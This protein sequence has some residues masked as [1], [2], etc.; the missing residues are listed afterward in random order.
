M[1][2]KLHAHQ[3]KALEEMKNG[4]ILYGGVGVGKTITSLAYYYTKVCGGEL[5]K[6]ASMS[7]P[8]DVYVITTA[9]VRDSQAF[10]L[11]AGK[12]GVHQ[13]PAVSTNGVKITVDSWNNLHKYTEVKDAFFI[14]DEQRVVGYGSWARA[15]I[16]VAKSNEWILLSATPG[17]TWLDYIP[18]FIANGWYKHKT[19]F[20]DQHVIWTPRV[21]YPKVLRYQNVGVLVKRRNEVLVHMPLERHTKR[22]PIDVVCDYDHDKFEKVVKKKWHVFDN[23]PLRDIAEQFSVMRKVV[24]SDAS[25][26]EAVQRILSR[27]PK[28]IVFYNFDYELE[29]LRTLI[30]PSQLASPESI[31]QM[32]DQ[33]NSKRTTSSRPS[34]RNSVEAGPRTSA[35]PSTSTDGSESTEG[36]TSPSSMT[37]TPT[38]YGSGSPSRSGRSRPLGLPI[39]E[40]SSTSSLTQTNSDVGDEIPTSA[41]QRVV[42]EKL[43][44]SSS[45]LQ[46]RKQTPATSHH[47][48]S[49]SLSSG[50][51]TTISGSGS[52]SSSSAMDASGATG[53]TA[54]STRSSPK[55]FS[56]SVTPQQRKSSKHS[57]SS[58]SGVGPRSEGPNISSDTSTLGK[59]SATATKKLEQTF[60]IAEWNGHKH[61]EIPTT[62]R[63]LYLVQYRAGAEGWNCI[64][65]D[66]IVFYSQ[67]Y[68]YRDWWQAHGR[69]DRINTRF[70]DLYYYYF[71]SDSIIDKAIRK[72]LRMKKSFNEKDLKLPKAA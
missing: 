13:L 16:K 26:L 46:S 12:M 2:V 3:T 6:W 21:K 37:T 69:I 71:I 15:F 38:E 18:V 59:S 24:N 45:S 1:S 33:I 27:H 68:S 57:A 17:D 29:A 42:T 54:H 5:N 67:T 43:V 39:W 11:Q 30:P 50:E 49:S 10:E 36:S 63:W 58:P 65:T 14:F 70:V 61:E 4:C 31:Q 51:S 47:V 60:S 19:D 28:L 7:T 52:K 53:P 34:G 72:A 64:E 9:K 55:H 25:R 44:E 56:S 62:E 40:S 48:K 41:S 22:H 66:A 35:S 23:R 32:A 8:K 20:I